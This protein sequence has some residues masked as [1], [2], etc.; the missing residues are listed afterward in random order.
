MPAN[1]PKVE[2][3]A[4]NKSFMSDYCRF[5][6]DVLSLPSMEGFD[7]DLTWGLN[8]VIVVSLNNYVSG[9]SYIDLKRALL[10]RQPKLFFPS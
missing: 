6:Q 5:A 8:K 10:G 9:L 1:M 7:A 4:S 2:A 3:H